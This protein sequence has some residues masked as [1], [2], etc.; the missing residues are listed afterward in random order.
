MKVS[1]GFNSELTQRLDRLR[2]KFT[3]QVGGISGGVR[4]SR[5][6]G[7]SNEFSDF[8]A[9]SDGDSLRYVDWNSYARLNKLFIKLYTEEK[10][11]LVNVL[12]DC[13]ASM[14]YEDKAYVSGLLAASLCY[15]ALNGGDRAR[16]YTGNN[17]LS[18]S[19]KEE[20]SKMLNCLD[21]I[22]YK[23]KFD[24]LDTVKG[25]NLNQRGRLIII[26]DCMYPTEEIEQAVKYAVYKKQE[27]SLIMLTSSEENEPAISG[28][29]ALKD[30][31]TDDIINVEVSDNL[32]F[33]Y[34]TALKNHRGKISHF[35]RKYG[36]EFNSIRA[37]EDFR[38]ILIKVLA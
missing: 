9:Y 15:A 21:G 7:S 35:C 13:S 32:I 19:S 5:E 34:K 11:T 4:R 16:L 31:E 2:L 24:I 3:K 36:V 10:Q 38:Q 14:D 27:L 6:K 37:E 1:D 12:M 25:A 8:R 18:L 20:L 33:A 23:G 26:S 30:S 28:S 22:E 17:S 29:V